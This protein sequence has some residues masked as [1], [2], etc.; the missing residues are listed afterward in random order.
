MTKMKKMNNKL[1]V[2]GALLC[3]LALVFTFCKNEPKAPVVDEKPAEAAKIPAFNRDSAFAFVAEQT[4]FGPRTP[5]SPAHEACKNWLSAELKSYG[6]EVIEQNF[7]AKAY[8]GTML[9]ST[10]IIGQYKPNLSR[11]ILLAAHWDSRPMADAPQSPKADKTKPVMGADDGASGV[12]ILLEIARQLQANPVDIGVDIVFFDA[13]DFGDYNSSG[14]TWCLGSQ[15]WSKNLHYKKDIRP[16]YG[17]LLDM[18]GATGARFGFDD[19]S[20][21]RAPEVLQKVWSLAKD[22]GYGQYFVEEGV[23]G[24]TDDH[25]YVNSI[26]GIKMIDI[27]NKPLGSQSGFVDHWHTTDDTIDKIDRFTLRAV[28]QVLLA[29]IYREYNG[30]L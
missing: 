30:E 3:T 4:E 7:Q 16:E 12:G 26:A 2:M 13:E 17:I 9:N 20:Y 8:T 14:D 24:I 10:N 28:G 25:A 27:I 23:G 6:L 22:M 29:V 15:H 18:V 21:Q 11:R 5:N 19:I 1:A